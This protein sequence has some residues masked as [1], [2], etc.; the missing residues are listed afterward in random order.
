VDIAVELFA[1]SCACARARH[2]AEREGKPEALELADAYA[3]IAR[4]RVRGLFRG[5]WSNEDRASYKM[6]QAAVAGRYSWLEQGVMPT[7]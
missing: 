6:A 5:L 3:K 1:V 4:H 2:L 7:Q